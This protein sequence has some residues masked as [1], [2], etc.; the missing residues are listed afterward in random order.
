[1]LLHRRPLTRTWP[2][3]EAS[4]KEGETK[5]SNRESC[6]FRNEADRHGQ[7]R[8]TPV[9]LEQKSCR[10]RSIPGCQSHC[11]NSVAYSGFQGEGYVHEK[12]DHRFC[13]LPG[14]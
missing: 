4:R 13:H 10:A 5:G 11:S 12:N 9:M 7:P 8:A 1:C 14:A 3:L 6:L 2:A